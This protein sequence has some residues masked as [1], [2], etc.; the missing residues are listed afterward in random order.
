VKNLKFKISNF[1]LKSGFTIVELLISIG[2]LLLLFAI[3]TINISP[4]PSNTYQAA[5]LDVLINDIRSQQTM[6]MADDSSY[7]V[8]FESGSYTLFK[9][10]SYIM[11]ASGNFI[12]NLDGPNNFTNV[13]LPNSSIIFSANSGDVAGYSSGTDSFTLSNSSTNKSTTVHVNKYGA[14]Y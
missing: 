1:K 10:S 14:T 3:A 12:V 8:H 7:G 6:A 2:I 5:N 9:G 13:T 4:L 11:G